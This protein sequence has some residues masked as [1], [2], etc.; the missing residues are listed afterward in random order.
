MS[1]FELFQLLVDL[2]F[3]FLI[4]LLLVGRSWRKGPAAA[5]ERQA[6]AEMVSGLSTLI[7]EMKETSATLEE[8]I[9]EKQVELRQSIAAAEE[10][11][12][13]LKETSAGLSMPTAVPGVPA[14]RAPVREEESRGGRRAAAPAAY[15]AAPALEDDEEDRRARYRQAVDYAAKGWSAAEISRVTRLP[16]GEIDLLIRTR[17]RSG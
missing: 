1:A 6:Y 14:P 17:G 15:T 5:E 4:L 3:L 10:Q 11:V 12:Q 16:R 7:R 9:T 13:R 2:A 8:R